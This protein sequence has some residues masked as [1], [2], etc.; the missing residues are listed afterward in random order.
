MSTANIAPIQQLSATGEQ[1]GAIIDKIE[2]AITGE[3]KHHVLMAC[4]TLALVMQYPNISAEEL[5][6]GVKRT[7]QFIAFY[8]EG[9]N[10]AQIL[11]ANQV[12]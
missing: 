3:P 4:L 12:N 11:T 8:L 1:V 7:S 9:I 6:E 10:G 5:Q 2:G